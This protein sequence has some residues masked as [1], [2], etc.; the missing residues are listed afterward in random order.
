MADKTALAYDRLDDFKNLRNIKRSAIHIDTKRTSLKSVLKILSA[1]DIPETIERE[2]VSSLK[3]KLIILVDK[4]MDESKITA[5]H[6]VVN[7]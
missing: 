5:K 7:L 2:L 1:H 6:A 3:V 4:A